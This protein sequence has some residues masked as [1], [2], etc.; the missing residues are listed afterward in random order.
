M[1]VT[2]GALASDKTNCYLVELVWKRGKWIAADAPL[3]FDL[4]TRTEDNDFVSLFRLS[5]STA[6]EILE[7][8]GWLRTE[9]RRK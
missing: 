3:E 2:G 9:V 4:I 7:G 6:S 8:S 1:E 5:C